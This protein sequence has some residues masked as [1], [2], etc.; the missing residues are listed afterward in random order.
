[1]S[2]AVLD[3]IETKV[4]KLIESQAEVKADLKYHIKRTD[5]LEEKVGILKTIISASK[6]IAWLGVGAGA[7]TAFVKLWQLFG[8]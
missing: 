7:I 2:K 8:Q 5:L 1:M 4:D 3:R 6:A